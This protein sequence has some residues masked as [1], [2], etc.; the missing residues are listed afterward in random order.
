MPAR[1]IPEPLPNW[2]TDFSGN[3]TPLTDPSLDVVALPDLF[4]MNPTGF[5]LSYE[6][7]VVDK[8]ITITSTRIIPPAATAAPMPAPQNNV[9]RFRGRQAQTEVP[10]PCY[11]WCNNALLEVQTSGK[12][13]KICQPGSAYLV[14]LDSCRACIDSHR[15]DDT[16]TDTF[17]QIAPQFQQ[18]MDY[19]DGF[20]TTTMSGTMTATETSGTDT[21][22]TVVPTS[23]VTA[24]PTSDITETEVPSSVPSTVTTDFTSTSVS[25]IGPE[26]PST[27]TGSE[28]TSLTVVV[29]T[30]GSAT[31]L[32]GSDLIGATLILPAKGAS[33]TEVVTSGSSTYTTEVPATSSLGDQTSAV[34]EPSDSA[35]ASGSA[36]AVETGNSM[37]GVIEVPKGVMFGVAVVVGFVL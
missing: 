5:G 34:E 7:F 17:L 29:P 15:N 35:S 22:T 8:A 28:V 16:T 30:E 1:A 10:A 9:T 12:T 2:N 25:G 24:I 37:A 36:P 6:I 14:S 3:N 23:S 31:T 27:Y 4:N 18:F 13:A 26:P 19:C 11:S 20:T 21:F 33:H 32:S